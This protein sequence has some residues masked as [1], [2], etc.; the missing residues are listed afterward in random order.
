[1]MIEDRRAISGLHE[2]QEVGPR[3]GL[4][5]VKTACPVKSQVTI[6]AIVGGVVTIN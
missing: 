6:T 1:M 3:Y 2:D 5:T 4:T